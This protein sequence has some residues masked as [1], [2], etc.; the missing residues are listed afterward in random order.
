MITA[1]GRDIKGAADAGGGFLG[2]AG[3]G[4]IL[5]RSLRI[6]TLLRPG[7]LGPGRLLG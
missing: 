5:G 4:R 7:F 3:T 1:V 2:R 6:V